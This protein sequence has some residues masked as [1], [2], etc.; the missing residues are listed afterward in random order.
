[1]DGVDLSDG[2][3]F[4]NGFPHEF[5]RWLRDERPAYWREPTSITPDGEGFWVLSRYADIAATI[6]NHTVFSSARG[7]TRENGGTAIKDERSAGDMLNQ[8]DNLGQSR[9][10]P[11]FGGPHA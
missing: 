8:A 11:D 6:R 5:F 7:G 2:Q 3:S 10:A 9:F 4:R 1:M